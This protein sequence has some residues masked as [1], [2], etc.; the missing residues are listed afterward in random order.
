[1]D[2]YTDFCQA[3]LGRTSARLRPG[4]RVIRYNNGYQLYAPPS[5]AAVR[6]GPL[7]WLILSCLHSSPTLLSVAASMASRLG[8][9]SRVAV[10]AVA[11]T[12]WRFRDFLDVG[13]NIGSSHAKT[14]GHAFLELDETCRSNETDWYSFPQF[15]QLVLTDA[16]NLACK[17]CFRTPIS[18][19][20]RLDS[21]LVMSIISDCSQHGCLKITF[22][23]GEPLTDP[24]IVRYVGSCC[25]RGI[26]P[27]ITTNGCFLTRPLSKALSRCGCKWIQVSLDAVSDDVANRISPGIDTAGIMSN[28]RSAVDEGM[29]IVVRMVV[30]TDNIRSVE[31]VHSFARD[32]GVSHLDLSPV[33]VMCHPIDS[34][35][36][37]T[38]LTSDQV[39]WLC[40]FASA[41]DCPPPKT[42][43]GVAQK[44]K[45][46][47]NAT[48]CGGIVNFL[49]VQP[50]GDVT[51]CPQLPD[52]RY[53]TLSG[54]RS[55][56]EVW[57]SPE[58]TAMRR[59]FIDQIHGSEVCGRCPSV[60]RCLSG[61]FLLKREAGMGL[62]DADPRCPHCTE[63]VSGIY[64]LDLRNK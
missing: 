30:S 63:P 27:Y 34:Q 35:V 50:D 59:R 19:R 21:H 11:A 2:M 3:C 55:L 13:E 36:R 51:L 38:A 7:Q 58:A 62:F 23:G 24:N 28:I 45:T 46:D 48:M 17:Y 56:S 10:E 20:G 8:H 42:S 64:D 1:M 6:L 15:V 44:W 12:V 16:C 32:V 41:N 39:Q 61:C 18:I 9:T 14:N 29:N 54:G 52:L 47:S 22:T 33:N 37:N 40:D 57:K 25:D 43:V 49:S 31:G 26:F 5:T 53:G 60:D 4:V